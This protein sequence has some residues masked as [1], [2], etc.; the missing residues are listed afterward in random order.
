VIAGLV[1]LAEDSMVIRAV[2]R[3]QLET[4]G[5]RVIEASNGAEALALCRTSTPDVVLLDIEM[6]VLDG[7]GVL[8]AIKGDPQ[9]AGIP[10][11]FLTAREDTESVVRAL[12]LGAHDYLRKPFEPA[13]LRARVS[14]ALR[15]KSLQDELQRRNEEL[16]RL[17]RIDSL[18]GLANRRHIAHECTRLFAASRR[19]HEPVGACMIDIDN[20]KA[21][22]DTWGHAAGD[23]VLVAVGDRIQRAI[24][25]ED[26]V[27]RWGGEEFL[28]LLVAGSSETVLLVGERARAAVAATPIRLRDG[29][30]VRVTASVGCASSSGG[31]PDELIAR[32]DQALYEAKHAGRNRTVAA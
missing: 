29:T 31:T 8:E 28:V 13:E 27:G 21:I 7:Y 25:A 26:L 20:F 16:D 9:L 24:R 19:R 3:Q 18:T 30:E 4:Q 14:A 11:V 17:S 10:I 6:P 32:S 22:N 12:E 23:V 2:V 15:M 5:H 1:L